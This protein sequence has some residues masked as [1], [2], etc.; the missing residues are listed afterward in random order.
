[1]GVLGT[2]GICEVEGM[3]IFVGIW[4]VCRNCGSIVF[5]G[6]FDVCVCFGVLA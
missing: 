4:C 2:L 3:C 5:L 1:M 6:V